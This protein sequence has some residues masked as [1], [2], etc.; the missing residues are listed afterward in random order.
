MRNLSERGG[1][2]KLR[3]YWESKVHVVVKRKSSDSPVYEVVPEGKGKSRVLHRNLLLPCDS[4]PLGK[5]EPVPAKQER[6]IQTYTRTR[7]HQINEPVE[8]SDSES[9]EVELV[10]CFSDDQKLS[11]RA[12]DMNPEAEPFA[13]ALMMQHGAPDVEELRPI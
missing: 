6:E 12:A 11:H 9:S 10:C 5:L 3:S 2:G 7:H 8:D 1:P 13:P 4:L